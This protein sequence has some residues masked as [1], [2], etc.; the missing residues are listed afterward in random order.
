MGEECAICRGLSDPKDFVTSPVCHHSLCETCYKTL[1]SNVCP[2]CR[3]N[4]G[5]VLKSVPPFFKKMLC[6]KTY[7]VVKTSYKALFD[8]S[9]R[10]EYE[11]LRTIIIDRWSC[12]SDYE[13]SNVCNICL[14]VSKN[15]ANDLDL[16][17]L[18]YAC[19]PLT[20]TVVV[21]ALTVLYLRYGFAVCNNISPKDVF[22]H[23]FLNMCGLKRYTNSPIYQTENSGEAIDRLLIVIHELLFDTAD[24]DGIYQTLNLMTNIT[25]CGCNGVR[26]LVS[27]ITQKD[28]QKADKQKG[29]EDIVFVPTTNNVS[30]RVLLE[31]VGDVFNKNAFRWKYGIFQEN[32]PNETDKERGLLHV[33]CFSIFPDCKLCTGMLDKESLVNNADLDAAISSLKLYMNVPTA[34]SVA[35]AK[36]N[37]TN[38]EKKDILFHYTD[39]KCAM[40]RVK[41]VVLH[42]IVKNHLSLKNKVFVSHMFN[43]L[44]STKKSSVCP[45]YYLCV[46]CAGIIKSDES[47]QKKTKRDVIQRKSTAVMRKHVVSL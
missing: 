28:Q 47:A 22:F 39:S 9:F 5:R 4:M 42:S 41:T 7:C 34:V 19:A 40:N 27:H 15:S 11:Y 23:F 2:F 1:N 20:K 46:Y 36:L 18:F 31:D 38:P 44:F 21:D 14:A 26:A 12:V 16:L 37:L 6:D 24:I 30:D 45:L 32:K 13:F 17:N 10:P 33:D 43:E 8:S 35:C 25:S 29:T 3:G